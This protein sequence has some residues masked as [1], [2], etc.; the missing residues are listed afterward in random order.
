ML[1]TE[2][3]SSLIDCLRLGVITNMV[4][5]HCTSVVLSYLYE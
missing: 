5:R 1:P 3:I 2:V 4:S